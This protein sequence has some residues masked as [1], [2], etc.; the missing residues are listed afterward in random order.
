MEWTFA[1]THA[2]FTIHSRTPHRDVVQP[3]SVDVDPGDLEIARA[4]RGSVESA[5]P[6]R[7]ARR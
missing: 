4:I 2:L 6:R 3:P 5:S 1:L 7:I